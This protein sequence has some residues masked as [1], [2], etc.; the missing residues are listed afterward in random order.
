[1][2]VIQMKKKSQILNTEIY[3]TKTTAKVT[4]DLT[5]T[6]KKKKKIYLMA[7]KLMKTMKEVMKKKRYMLMKMMKNPGKMNQHLRRI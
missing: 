1:M 4:Q 3:S 6:T 7:A 5:M 2:I